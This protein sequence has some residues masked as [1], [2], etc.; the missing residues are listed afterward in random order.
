MHR[1]CFEKSRHFYRSIL[2][3]GICPVWVAGLALGFAADRF[4][5]D[6]YC[7][8]LEQAPLW[9]PDFWGLALVNIFPLLIS[10]CAVLIFPALLYVLCLFR[11]LM[12]GIGLLG[13]IRIYGQAGPMMAGLLLFSLLLFSPVMLWYWDRALNSR[14]TGLLADTLFCCSAALVLLGADLWITAP[15]LREIMIF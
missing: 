2:H 3:T 14:H 12:L 8:L 13:C 15:F 4:C 6:L 11:G 7:G 5:G 9:L 1:R 10:A